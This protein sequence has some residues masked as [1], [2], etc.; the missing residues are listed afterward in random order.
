MKELNKKIVSAL[1]SDFIG[2]VVFDEEEIEQLKSDCRNFYK[3]A[4]SSW[5]KIY[6]ADDIAKLLVL[7]VNTVKD[8]DDES[9]G[10]FW[11][12]LFGE[13]F[14]DGSI[15]PSKFYN[16]FEECLKKYDKTLFRSRENK[17]MFREV[18]LLHALA[19]DNSGASFIR[20]LWNWYTDPDLIDFDYQ[21]G[22]SIYKQMADY[23]EH[24]F[25]GESDFD[26][27][28]SFEGKTYAI[29]SSF[30][31]LF[32]QNKPSGLKLLDKIYA[33]FDSI[34][35]HGTFN[36]NSYIESYCDSVVERILN[37]ASVDR[38]KRNRTRREHTVVSDYDRIYASYEILDNNEIAIVLPEIRAIN[39]TADEF[40][41]EVF[42][43]EN[44]IFYK[45]DYVV[46]SGLKRRINK[47]VIP[48]SSFYVKVNDTLNL[49]VKLSLYKNEDYVLLYDSKD[50]LYRDFI[51]FKST[52]ESRSQTCKPG[53]YFVAHPYGVD[54]EKISSLTCNDVN[55]YVS[56]FS[57]CENDYISTESQSVF[58]NQQ[59]QDSHVIISG[60][61]LEG[62][63]FS[64]NGISCPM[65]KKLAYLDVLLDKNTIN[66]SIAIMVDLDKHYSLVA[67]SQRIENG[68]RID[69]KK[70]SADGIGLHCLLISDVSKKKLLHRI[71]YYII[72]GASF[73]LGN[74]FVFG[75]KSV[76]INFN[77]AASDGAIE[78]VISAIPRAG[79]ESV[80]GEFD[81]GEIIV[82]VPYVKWR[83]NDGDWNYV[84]SKGEFWREE[85][86]LH[87]NCT[88]EVENNSKY[89]ID[90]LINNT[91]IS[92]NKNG[93]YL[94]GD[95][96][97][98]NSGRDHN[99]ISLT[100]GENSFAL[101][102]VYNKEKLTGIDID[103]YD[104][105]V[106]MSAYFIGAPD[107]RFIVKL[108]NDVNCYQF[109]SGLKSSFEPDI[110]DGE[111]DVS[112][113]L[114]DFWENPVTLYEDY[115]V[116]GNP[117]KFCFDNKKI[118][119]K[120]FKK[121]E[122]GK[123]KLDNSSIVDLKYLREEKIGVVYSGVLINKKKRFNVEVYKK[124]ENSL[125]F[126]F[127]NGD[128]LCSANYDLKK[129]EFTKENT[130]DD[131]ASIIPCSSCYYNLEEVA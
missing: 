85:E 23:L 17:R 43:N 116:V 113:A 78:R 50:G 59:P 95:A 110:V 33:T 20:L 125:K 75:E 128:N 47:I 9:E 11:T 117:D 108:E 118:I 49:S 86:F 90:L 15:S 21:P 36:N 100:I 61:K 31:Y 42:N 28:M 27:A 37:E 87:N 6:Y 18:F 51:V 40:R 80:S 91:P 68:R 107:S 57:A 102:D 112:I 74:G 62:V 106:D 14:D 60:E 101:F 48:F 3:R 114:L 24:E 109:H 72:N 58:F 121:N 53:A 104:K 79:Q 130:R 98:E 88:I 73:L 129:N 70:L 32:T 123:V 25:G 126:Y 8:W 77:H 2:D 115:C 64:K 34:Y 4:Q 22:D 76:V 111:Y 81:G 127:V 56:A 99:T 89:S 54:M 55:E 65:Y 12:K 35:F 1:E 10:R 105:I 83:I 45:D 71:D 26:E 82:P 92:S 52:R 93:I 5:S 19:P 120:T 96:L 94:L 66:E 29:K 30:K 131:D 16:E 84:S 97:T 124:D 119:L 38:S 103:I 44:R 41:I 63:S 7:I 122:G 39:E 69:L 13:I 46:G 67:N